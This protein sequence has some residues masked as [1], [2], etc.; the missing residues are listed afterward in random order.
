[1]VALCCAP[2]L[3]QAPGLPRRLLALAHA[4]LE[5]GWP[6]LLPSHQHQLQEAGQGP[7]GGEAGQG[8]QAGGGGGGR[9]LQRQCLRL[10]H[11][12]L[13]LLKEMV[14]GARDQ[15]C[16][17]AMEELVLEPDARHAFNITTS[18]VSTWLSQP[19]LAA[20]AA[21][22]AD[23]LALDVRVTAAATAAAGAGPATKQ[24][25]RPAP[26][27]AAGFLGLGWQTAVCDERG[28]LGSFDSD[29]VLL[30]PWAQAI[31]T[32]PGGVTMCNGLEQRRAATSTPHATATLMS[33]LSRRFGTHI[34]HI[35]HM[36]MLQDQQ[37]G[38]DTVML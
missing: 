38:G 18:L 28:G 37:Q 21:A 19:L 35:W 25:V 1:L 36:Q 30:A 22:Q 32:A 23:A 34:A 13:L 27:A 10:A 26:S 24:A 16:L 20:R 9:G 33:S 12:A 7:G 14:A 11:E 8:Q 29:V 3:H 17:V 15:L 5:A 31:A 6:Q 2:W 4:A